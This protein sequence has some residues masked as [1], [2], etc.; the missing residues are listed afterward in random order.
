M[1]KRILQW[2][3]APGAVAM[4]N[5]YGDGE[6]VDGVVT[7]KCDA[8][9]AADALIVKIGSDAAHVAVT[10]ANTDVPQGVTNQPTDAIEDTVAVRLLGKGGTKLV[11]ASEAIAAGDEVVATAAGKAAKLPTAGGTYY[12]IGRALTAAAADGDVFELHDCVPA[13]RVVT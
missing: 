5:A 11:T 1:M 12:V 7:R 8:V 13:K 3:C 4:P 9:L 6:H 2:L 10:A